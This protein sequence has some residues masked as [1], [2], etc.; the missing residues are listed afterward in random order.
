MFESDWSELSYKAQQIRN[1][2]LNQKHETDSYSL[3]QVFPEGKEQQQ[4]VK[5]RINQDFFRKTVL[6]SYNF[7][8]CI[9]GLPLPQL[10]IASHIKPWKDSDS[11]TERTDPRNGLLLNSF[12]DRAF[13]KGLIT[14]DKKYTIHVSSSVKNST[15]ESISMWMSR[16]HNQKITLPQRFIP[17]HKYIEYHNDVIFQK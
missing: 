15:D 2:R 14:I 1:E 7:K 9:T 8:C 16:Y 13:D 12:H 6:A 10:L 5:A 3:P 4:I 11:L 17:S